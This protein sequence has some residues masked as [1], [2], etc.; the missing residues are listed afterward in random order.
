MRLPPSSS[1]ACKGCSFCLS[2]ARK[3]WTILHCCKGMKFSLQLSSEGNLS[4]FE[5]WFEKA[6][7]FR[8]F[9]VS[10]TL[11]VE[12]SNIQSVSG[13]S[14]TRNNLSKCCL[15]RFL[16]NILTLPLLVQSAHIQGDNSGFLIENRFLQGCVCV[17]FLKNI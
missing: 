5:V 6:I 4:Y 13:S 3:A 17:R 14:R 11:R 16:V 1:T 8:N 7:S 10:C 2:N 9:V 15:Y 12:K